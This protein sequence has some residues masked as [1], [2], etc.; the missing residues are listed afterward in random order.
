MTEQSVLQLAVVLLKVKTW[1]NSKWRVGT[2]YNRIGWQVYTYI[3]YTYS[4]QNLCSSLDQKQS[5]T[6]RFKK[7]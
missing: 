2:W 5:K 4:E 6:K 7:R 1:L 3:M